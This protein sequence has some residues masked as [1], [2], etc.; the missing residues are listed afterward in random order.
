VPLI[1]SDIFT[2]ELIIKKK[3]TELSKWS[4]ANITEWRLRRFLD[5]TYINIDLILYWFAEEA[6]K[7]FP[8]IRWSS[9]CCRR[10][11]P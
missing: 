8:P 6:I 9:L 10:W 5:A 11:K 2:E 4:P 7:S 1:H 3:V